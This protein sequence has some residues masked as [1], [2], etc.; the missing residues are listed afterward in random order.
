MSEKYID[1]LS[2]DC[3]GNLHESCHGKWCGLSFEIYCYCDCHKNKALA[4]VAQ[5]RANATNVTHLQTASGAA[6]D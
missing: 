6:S 5:P 2:R 1:F 4:E 3:K